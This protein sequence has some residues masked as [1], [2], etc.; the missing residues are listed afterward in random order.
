MD[1]DYEAG[2]KA[3]ARE[4]AELAKQMSREWFDI[5]YDT[6]SPFFNGKSDGANELAAAIVKRFGL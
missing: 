2:R 3:A 1:N 4:C 6:N 5:A